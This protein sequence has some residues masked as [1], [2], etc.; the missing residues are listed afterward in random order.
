MSSLRNSD[1]DS[2]GIRQYIVFV[3]YLFFQ[4]YDIFVRDN[5]ITWN[6]VSYPGIFPHKSST[7][8]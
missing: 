2:F 1:L 3:T 8:L 6:I 5:K 4:I 7:V